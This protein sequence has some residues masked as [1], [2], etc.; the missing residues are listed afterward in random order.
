M[1]NPHEMAAVVYAIDGKAN[2]GREFE[3]FRQPLRIERLGEAIHAQS[4]PVV[5]ERVSGS[6]RVALGF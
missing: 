5:L 2:A 4:I 6:R 1:L 3:V